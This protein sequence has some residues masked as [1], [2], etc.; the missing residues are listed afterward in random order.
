MVCNDDSSGT[1]QSR[2]SFLAQ[3]GTTYYVQVGGFNNAFGNLVVHFTPGVP[4]PANDAFA[5]AVAVTTLPSQ[6]TAITDSASTEAGE[7]T[8]FACGT[9]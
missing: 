4:P 9:P 5:A 8:A 7:P 1:L 2:V 6:F 3:G